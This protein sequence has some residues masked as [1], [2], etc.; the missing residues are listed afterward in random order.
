MN[1][2]SFIWVTHNFEGFHNYPDAPDEVA[3]LRNE[4]RHM[5]HLKVWIEVFHDDRDIEFFMFKNFIK[6]LIDID[7]YDYMSCEMISDNLFEEITFKY[8]ARDIKIDVSEDLE[9]G[10]SITYEVDK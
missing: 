9:N 2:K 6:A 7:S 3:F 5:F 8:P 4:H 1:K 10:S